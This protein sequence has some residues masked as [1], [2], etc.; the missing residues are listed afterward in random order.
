MALRYLLS[1][2]PIGMPKD[3][4]PVFEDNQACMKMVTN[5]RGWKHVKHIDT[6]LHFVRDIA[7]AGHVDIK[8]VNTNF[9]VADALTKALYPAKF[10]PFR[11]RML[12]LLQDPTFT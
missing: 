6:R 4:T 8:Y 7:D 2:L 5:P 1:Q 12:G 11:D 3:A 10:R 9:Q